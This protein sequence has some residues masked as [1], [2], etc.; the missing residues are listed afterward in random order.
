MFSMYRCEHSSL[1]TRLLT[2]MRVKH[3]ITAYTAVFL[4]MNP[5]GSKHIKDNRNSNYI[6]IKKSV[7]SVGLCCIIKA[8]RTVQNDI[9]QW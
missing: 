9:K 4:M 6:S 3:T 5:R 1:P 7:H 8:Q 2:P